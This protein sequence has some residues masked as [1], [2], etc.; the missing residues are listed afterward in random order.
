M[1]YFKNFGIK[2]LIRLNYN[3]L[4]VFNTALA[5]LFPITDDGSFTFIGRT[6]L[7][8]IIRRFLIN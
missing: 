8:T 6:L 3:V 5:T 7:F 1:R 2:Y 4:H